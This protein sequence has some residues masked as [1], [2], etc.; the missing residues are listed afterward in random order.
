MSLRS[1]RVLL[2][3]SLGCSLFFGNAVAFAQVIVP[4]DSSG[5][6]S[7]P[8][9]SS[10][11]PNSTT[12]IDSSTRFSCQYNNGMPT[13]MYQPESQA[14]QY[15]AWAAP[16]NLGGGWDS[17]KRCETIANRLELYRPD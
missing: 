4:T 5:S 14:G 3:S 16:Q 2:L 10:T 7:V 1:L 12:T 17:Q 15:F 13:V 11:T 8:S 9:G 6:T